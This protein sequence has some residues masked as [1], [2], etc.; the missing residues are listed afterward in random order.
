M[1]N[2]RSLV[3]IKSLRKFRKTEHKVEK[4]GCYNYLPEWVKKSQKHKFLVLVSGLLH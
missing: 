3:L 1:P 4:T 2:L